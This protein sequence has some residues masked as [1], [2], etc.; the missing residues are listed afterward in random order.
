MAAGKVTTGLVE[1]NGS[2]A[3]RPTSLRLGLAPAVHLVYE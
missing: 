2:V 1:S 3:R